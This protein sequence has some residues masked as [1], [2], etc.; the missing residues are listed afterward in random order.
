MLEI[1]T[2][3]GMETATQRLLLIK[4]PTVLSYSAERIQVGGRA[5]GRPAGRAGGPLQCSA[6]HCLIVL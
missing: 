6:V 1:L 5:G 4:S 3:I 2:R